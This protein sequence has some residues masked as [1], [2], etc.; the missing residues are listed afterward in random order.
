MNTVTKCN[1]LKV[2]CAIARMRMYNFSNQQR[3]NSTTRGTTFTVKNC[4]HAIVMG[5]NTVMTDLDIDQQNIHG[6]FRC[7]SQ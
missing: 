7:D 6:E 2:D 1:V 3:I 4:V 5:P